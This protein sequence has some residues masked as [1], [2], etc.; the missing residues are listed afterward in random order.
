MCFYRSQVTD[1]ALWM[2]L[3]SEPGETDKVWIISPGAGKVYQGLVV[4]QQKLKGFALL[5]PVHR[6]GW[7]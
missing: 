1:L 4:V 6:T 5:I 3:E 2:L 7:P